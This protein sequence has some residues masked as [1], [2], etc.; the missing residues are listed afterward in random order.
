M[1]VY[2]DVTAD[3]API[4]SKQSWLGTKIENPPRQSNPHALFYDI[5]AKDFLDQIFYHRQSISIQSRH[6]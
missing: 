5:E 2:I 4:T 3:T 6:L 1:Q